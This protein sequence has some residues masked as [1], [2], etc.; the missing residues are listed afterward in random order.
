VRRETTNILLVLVGGALVKIT[1]DGTYLRYVKPTVKPWVLTAGIVMIALALAAIVRDILADQTSPTQSTDGWHPAAPATTEPVMTAAVTDG[2]HHS[3]RWTWL[4]M[5][6]VLAI[7]L[8]SPPALGADSVLRAGNRTA[9]AVVQQGSAAFPPL[10][11]EAAV[12]LS[13]SEFITRSVWD[14]SHSLT[15]ATVALT[16]FVVHANGSDY[17]A[18]LVITCC[19]ADATPMKVALTGGQAAPLLNDQ[20]IRVTGRLRAGSATESNG[21]TPTL[22]VSGLTLVSAP[23]DPYEY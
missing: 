4:L 23:A 16:G 8:I 19:A 7:F 12:P 18:R 22:T 13:M 6:P 17:V 14:S 2:H 21:Y 10:P 11:K 1:V 9:P 15:G 3:A 20:W 5:L